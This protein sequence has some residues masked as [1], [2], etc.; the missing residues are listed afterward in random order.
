MLCL[1]SY[2]LGGHYVNEIC[3]FQM[4]DSPEED[5]EQACDDPKDRWTVQ[6]PEACAPPEALRYPAHLRGSEQ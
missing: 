4:S 1:L 3:K 6:P 2:L 5:F